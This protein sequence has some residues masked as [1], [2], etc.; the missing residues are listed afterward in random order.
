MSLFITF[1]GGEGSGKSTQANIL[2]EHLRKEKYKVIY[3]EEPGTTILGKMLKE[4]LRNRSQALTLIPKEGDQLFLLEDDIDDKLLPDI[5]L[6]AAAPRAELLAFTIARAQL[7]EEIII[8]SLKNNNIVICDRFADSTIAYQGYGRGLDMELIKLANKIA[9]QG[10][11]PDLTILLD[12]PPEAGL[13]RKFGNSDEDH[14][15]KQV[16]DFHKKVRGGYL[17]LAEQEPERWLVIDAALS[18]KKIEQLIFNKVSQLLSKH[19]E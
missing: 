6:H 1:E 18:K 15:E 16:L 17:K 2:A 3:C 5:L 12:I 13:A 11:K 8:P 4:W 10:V 9:T 14:F 7:I 19:K